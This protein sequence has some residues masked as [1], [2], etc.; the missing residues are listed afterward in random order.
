MGRSSKIT[1][2]S[3][4][5]LYF[6]NCVRAARALTGKAARSIPRGPL[7]YGKNP[8]S[9]LAADNLK[10]SQNSIGGY[11]EQ[12]VAAEEVQVN[13]QR[14]ASFFGSRLGDGERARVETPLFQASGS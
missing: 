4:R 3:V 9:R 1:S 11:D 8:A 13:A 7:R 14:D 5:Q 2:C 10:A 6:F 12:S